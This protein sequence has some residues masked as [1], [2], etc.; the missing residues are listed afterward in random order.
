MYSICRF[1]P[2]DWS[3]LNR[4]RL[5][6]LIL[7]QLVLHGEKQRGRAGLVVTSS[8]GHLIVDLSEWC[9]VKTERN[10]TSLVIE[11][12]R[13]FAGD[14]LIQIPQGLGGAGIPRVPEIR[15]TPRGLEAA[16]LSA[17]K[18]EKPETLKNASRTSRGRAPS[19][20]AVEDEKRPFT[21]ANLDRY[22]LKVQL[23]WVLRRLYLEVDRQTQTGQFSLQAIIKDMGLEPRRIMEE[24]RERH[25]VA[26]DRAGRYWLVDID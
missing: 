12:L 17:K 21:I 3:S 5:R 8:K 16:S 2:S 24:L 15:V 14:G 22:P 11:D 19:E 13:S 1:I 9:G 20:E 26:Y 23:A 10:G 18:K 4:K 6:S 7:S 25:L